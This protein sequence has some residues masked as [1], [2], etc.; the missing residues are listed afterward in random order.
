M[1]SNYSYKIGKDMQTKKRPPPLQYLRD[2]A[3]RNRRTTVAQ[4]EPPQLFEVFVQLQSNW[5]LC[6]QLHQGILAF[7][8]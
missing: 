2:H 5:P 4:H 3:C 1:L 6:L 8:Q 7:G